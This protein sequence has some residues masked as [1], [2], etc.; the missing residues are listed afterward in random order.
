MPDT[1]VEINLSHIRSNAAAIA[2]RYPMY[3]CLIGVVKGDAYGH[4]YAVVQAMRDGGVGMFAVS[5]VDEAHDFRR[6]S[7]A[8]LLCLQPV[9]LDRLDE[10][11]ELSL[12][13]P[14]GDMT[15]LRALIARAHP[16]PFAIHLQVDAGF[17]RL[18]FKDACEIEQALALL[19]SSP[20]RVEGI[21]QHFAT[22]GVFDPYYDRQA[23]RFSELTEG[24]DLH[25]IPLVHLGSGVALLAHDKPDAATATR[26]GL[27]LYGYNITP[28]SYGGGVKDR[29]RDLRDR[30]Y[31]KKYRLSATYRDVELVLHPAMRMYTRILQLKNVTAGEHIGYNA[32]YTAPKDMRIAVLPVG[33]CNGIGHEDHGRMVQIGDN[34][35][36]VVGEIGMNML[37][38]KVD[39]SVMPDDRVTLLGGR[40]TLGM[41]ARA[42]GMGL[43]EALLLIGK[44]NP[45]VYVN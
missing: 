27:I 4:G 15:Y 37:C 39:D 28:T 34:L 23:A 26:M 45:R 3:D 20:Y 2:A 14:V 16:Y 29:L 10:A 17:N 25:A 36:P 24:I 13:L 30:Y 5:S 33:Y 21:Y 8:P 42:A 11:A 19:R 41:F 18:G 44:N 38:V 7:D 32:A 9:S 6:Y 31:Q 40:I 22:A 1:V 43:A 35:Y 12:T